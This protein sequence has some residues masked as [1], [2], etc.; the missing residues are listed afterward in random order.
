MLMG[1]ASVTI[2]LSWQIILLRQQVD[3]LE[4]QVLDLSNQ[5]LQ[6]VY[7]TGPHQQV[8]RIGVP[9]SVEEAMLGDAWSA[10]VR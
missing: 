9:Y 10:P 7:R 3:R 5:P 1:F 8:T 2:A 4:K 6:A